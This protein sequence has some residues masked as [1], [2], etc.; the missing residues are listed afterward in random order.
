[1][2]RHAPGLTRR[3]AGRGFCFLDRPGKTIDDADRQLIRALAIPPAWCE[4]W[5]CPWPNGHIQATGIDA[6]GRR[7]YLYHAQ[8]RR[9]RDEEKFDRVL[10]LAPTLPDF[11]KVVES[12]LLSGGHG[13]H[14]ALA[15]AL[16]M[17][18]H[19]VSRVG[20]RRDSKILCR[21]PVGGPIPRRRHDLRPA[22]RR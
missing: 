16:R 8:W 17:L 9:R 14:R 13:Q 3:R 20:G 11:R 22:A 1:M 10:E 5:I 4:V 21:P 6:D 7:Q 19:V 15:T 12:D 18:D 2:I